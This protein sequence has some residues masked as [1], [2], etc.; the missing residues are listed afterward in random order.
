MA[1]NTSTKAVLLEGGLV[2][3]GSGG[4]SWPGDVLLQGSLEASARVELDT[5]SGD[6]RV[7]LPTLEHA[8]YAL[9]TFSGD[10]EGFLADREVSGFGPGSTVALLEGDGTTGITVSTHSGDI[11]IH[12]A[13]P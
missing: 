9:S 8:A 2:V 12:R 10:I 11:D 3:D 13:Q 7:V 1:D 4:P 5:H 6:V